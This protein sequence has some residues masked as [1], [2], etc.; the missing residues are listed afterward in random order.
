MDEKR[1]EVGT[2]VYFGNVLYTVSE[3]CEDGRYKIR[4]FWTNKLV[5]T[6]SRDQIQVKG[7]TQRDKN[8]IDR[9]TEYDYDRYANGGR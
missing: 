7:L 8:R 3:V 5:R 9:Q 4:N 1:L 2:D 6:V